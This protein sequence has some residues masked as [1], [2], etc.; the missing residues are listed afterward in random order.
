[1]NK[2]ND[3]II[4]TNTKQIKLF[5]KQLKKYNKVYRQALSTEKTKC[6]NN[7][8]KVIIKQINLVYAKI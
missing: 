5:I 7:L 3:N 6:L 1:M 8:V 2:I 4:I